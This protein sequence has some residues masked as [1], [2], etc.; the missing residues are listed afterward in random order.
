M[1]SLTWT[2]DEVDRTR[3]WCRHACVVCCVRG[4]PALCFLSPQRLRAAVWCAVQRAGAATQVRRR[5]ARLTSSAS[6]RLNAAR[7]RRRRA[8]S[9]AVAL[10]LPSKTCSNKI[11]LHQTITAQSQ[12]PD[13]VHE[14]MFE[15][16]KAGLSGQSS[17]ST[18]RVVVVDVGSGAT[19]LRPGACRAWLATRSC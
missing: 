7:S 3:C 11:K 10:H 9:A 1:C 14:T 13:Y 18:N 6:A 15:D 8:G 17:F 19:L 2:R 12:R 5:R 16:R 4:A